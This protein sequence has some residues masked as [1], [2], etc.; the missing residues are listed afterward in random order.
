MTVQ[1]AAR[2]A[3]EE[4]IKTVNGSIPATNVVTA[5]RAARRC[6]LLRRSRITIDEMTP[7][8]TWGNQM[9]GMAQISQVLYLY[10]TVESMMARHASVINRAAVHLSRARAGRLDNGERTKPRTVPPASTTHMSSSAHQP[11]C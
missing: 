5:T 8:S 4:G 2:S 10:S 11:F 6:A 1:T 3:E 7:S 9:M